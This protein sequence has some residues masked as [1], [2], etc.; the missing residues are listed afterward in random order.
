VKLGLHRTQS[1]Y[2]VRII[3]IKDYISRD[4]SEQALSCLVSRVDLWANEAE[5]ITAVDLFASK[6]PQSPSDK[7][8]VHFEKKLEWFNSLV[9]CEITLTPSEG[10]IKKVIANDW[11][12]KAIMWTEHR[13]YYAYVWTTTV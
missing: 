13:Q 11:D 9:P 6:K 7:T 3:A 10:A 2:D 8:E 1:D 4:G 5:F 12:C